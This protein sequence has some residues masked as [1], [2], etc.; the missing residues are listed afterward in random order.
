MNPVLIRAELLNS[1]VALT[2]F[3]DFLLGADQGVANI[4]GK[5][6]STKI[7]ATSSSSATA[8]EGAFLSCPMG[9]L[10]VLLEHPVLP[11]YSPW[12]RVVRYVTIYGHHA[13]HNIILWA[14][15]DTTNTI[16]G[17]HVTH[18]TPYMGIT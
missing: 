18:T 11:I 6:P 1:G 15:R 10:M 7:S 17:H 8:T 13:T 14:S 12:E 4:K 16:Y 2:D 5:A 3:W 9:Q